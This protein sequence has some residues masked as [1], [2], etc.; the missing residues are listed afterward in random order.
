MSPMPSQDERHQFE[1]A[2]AAVVDAAR[3]A[4]AARV[5]L[6]EARE[7]LRR[8]ERAGR[9][10]AIHEG[11]VK[12][13]TATAQDQIG[14]FTNSREAFEAFTDPRVGA[15]MLDDATPFLLFPLRI[16]TRFGTAMEHGV[17]KA[18]LWVRVYPDDCLIDSFEPLP[19]ETEI[20][21]A[22]RYWANMWK[23]HGIEAQE[24][25]AWRSFVASHGSGRAAWLEVN[26]KP[27]NI[28]AKPNN[29]ATDRLV[30]VIPTETPIVNPEADEVSTFWKA[31]WLADGK[32]ADTDQ[33]TTTLRTNIGNDT[34][35]QALIDG[36]KP[37]NLSDEPPR[38]LARNQ[39]IV[40]VAFV[41]FPKTADQ[42]A[43]L[44][45][46]SQPARSHL[47]P[48]RFVLLAYADG[49]AKVI[50]ELGNPIPW[51]LTVGPDP[52]APDTE[53]I[54]Q[55]N[56]EIKVG[57][58]LKWL[59]DFERA[60]Q[61]GMGFRV[62]L[63]SAMATQGFERLL[64]IGLRLSA[65]AMEGKRLLENLL[66]H[67]RDGSSG[68]AVLKQGTP[69]NNTEDESSGFTRTDEA[70]RTFDERLHP[71]AA[72]RASAPWNKKLDGEWL[73]DALGIDP[74]LLN[75]V[76][77]SRNTDQLEAQAMN[78]ALWPATL[79]YSLETMM[80]PAFDGDDM[81]GVRWFYERFVTGRGLLPAIRL[82]HQPYGILPT[83]VMS[84]LQWPD[85]RDLRDIRGAG[86]PSGFRGVLSG[87]EKVLKVMGGDWAEMAKNVSR[88][89]STGDPHQI[90]LDIIGLHP[91]SVE[92]Y[93]RYAESLDDLYNRMRFYGWGAEFMAQ[94]TA[95]EYEV[96]GMAHL[97]HL[98]Y[99]GDNMPDIL[100]RFFIQSANLLQGPFVDDLPLSETAELQNVTTD[101]WNYIEW[102]RSAAGTSLDKLR[103]ETGFTGNKVPKALLYLLLRHALL[104]AYWDSSLRLSQLREFMDADAI[105]AARRESPFIH[106]QQEPRSGESRWRMLYGRNA[107]L[108]G[109]PAV[110]VADYI[111][112]VIGTSPAASRLERMLAA[113]DV[114]KNLPTARLER[115][116]A[117]HLDTC[118]Y[119]LDAW[120]QGLVHY[121]LSLTR[122]K[123]EAG[124]T[125][126]EKGIFLGTFGW[127]EEVRPR[128]RK[129]DPVPP[130][131]GLHAS[132]HAAGLQPLVHDST[133]GG[134][135]HAP[136][137]N[138]AVAA[139]VLRNG[140]LA[141][142]TPANPGAFAVNLSSQR[143]RLALSFLEGIR[144]GQSLGAL[145]GYQ[146]ERGLHDA[147]VL[148]EVDEHIHALR[149]KFPLVADRH[150]DTASPPTASIETIEARNVVDGL[151]L[152]EHVKNNPS[153]S[154]PFGFNDL[155]P[156]D[157]AQRDAINAEVARLIDTTD[158][159]ADLKVA[160]SVY[161]AVQSNY[162]GVAATLESSGNG[163]L[164]PEPAVIETPRSGRT[165]THRVAL[166]LRPGL[167]MDVTPAVIGIMPLPA[168]WMTPRGCA[169]PALN[170]W[171]AKML[172]SPDTVACMVSW[173]DPAA[174]A[175]KTE[176]V[177]QENIGL[178][179]IDLLYTASLETE[180]AM[181]EL[182]DRIVLYAHRKFVPRADCPVMIL[183]RMP[184][185]GMVTF[186]ELASLI[187]SLRPLVL[188][189]RPLRPTDAVAQGRASSSM[190]ALVKVEPER[191]TKVQAALTTLHGN[192]VTFRDTLEPLHMIP[193]G[194]TQAAQAAREAQIRAG[195][196]NRLTSFVDLL[197]RASSFGLGDAGWGFILDFK[198]TWFESLLDVVRKLKDRFTSRLAEC[199]LRLAAYDLA[200]AGMTEPERF[201]ALAAA[202][203][204]VRAAITIPPPANAAAYRLAVGV[205]RNVFSARLTQLRN[206]LTM[207][208]QSVVTLHTA[209]RAVVN[210]PPLLAELDLELVDLTD[211]DQAL[212]KMSADLLARSKRLIKIIEDA[213]L[214]PAADLIANYT[215]AADPAARA[216]LLVEAAKKL[217]GDDA[218]LIPEFKLD[219]DQGGTLQAAYNAGV[220]GDP[221]IWQ[222]TVKMTPEP[223]DT[224]LYGI[225]RVREK[226]Q[227][228]EQSVMLEGAFGAAE[229]ELVPIQI[230]WKAGE[231]W[232]G[233]EYPLT[234]VPD[235]DRLCY[236]AHFVQPF[237]H[238]Q[239]QSGLLIDD[240]TEVIPAKQETTGLTFHF[241]RP[242]AEAP[243]ALLL[244]T[245]PAFIGSW[246]WQDIV[247][248]VRETLD[249]SKSRAV[250]PVHIDDT[251]Y[252]RFLP[253]T[254]MA[255]TLYQVSIM[256][257]L[258]RNNDYFAYLE[259]T[260]G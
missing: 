20:A 99:T 189:S 92:H 15:P 137:L 152:V 39:V 193:P 213:R 244:V 115:L 28:G 62:D 147:W 251:A 9:S 98:G 4:E 230:P 31:V 234:Y 185:A 253:M 83:T 226:M 252:A 195:L 60:V 44:R 23:A 257:N 190:D 197:V 94:L 25:G 127:L 134:Y 6:F 5:S 104:Q 65:D 79:G 13:R 95:I 84:R 254:V 173:F 233:L 68:F 187:R 40:T 171:L 69:T 80:H 114:L 88:V 17:P 36:Y 160:D 27:L 118:T 208:T 246:Q 126:T 1:A 117:E 219:D 29:L 64:V 120:Q 172:P 240:W 75:T 133:N 214:T 183:Y 247:D 222:R 107:Q 140:Y 164:P 32:R 12:D 203:R 180:Q 116:F 113:L 210:G 41:E 155:P 215:A 87:I 178:Q 231:H 19:S 141:N 248:A 111:T 52:Q 63:T 243:Q 154:Y 186:F 10:R 148:G 77:G 132:F 43:T 22:Q 143:V 161:H 249:R 129:L 103:E 71:G 239:W 102:L 165:V 242:N 50:E 223:A 211:F 198:R 174:N 105:K 72:L 124:A 217:L 191:I 163:Q 85:Q 241:D 177:T 209:V 179:P 149:K 97:A 89:G 3:K 96:T 232:L 157:Q 106:I 150:S 46:W 182:D 181:S 168:N 81:D 66:S 128:M 34:R 119:R 131:P 100:N 175:L 238:T 146:L 170:S 206:L 110:R 59:T 125:V 38:G 176:T 216:Q 108:T 33:A 37:I 169:E 78:V 218:I 18:Q 123:T 121:A 35:A 228:W 151:R 229:P 260:D 202:E 255:A 109:D 256:T 135:I 237:D 8:A 45:S 138:Q 86:N 48:D 42:A 91:A 207:A 14:S 2:Q 73:A 225:A 245:P 192:L 224:W 144:Q 167:A 258:A 26:Y 227:A 158:A 221:L 250:E 24:R 76:G 93:Q 53:Q 30:L 74:A 145:L 54:R 259:A 11:R 136:S 90:L 130:T 236:T 122:Y 49:G 162:D 47:L 58:D 196:D 159:I 70:D 55:E 220:N 101:P 21:S 204:Y 7:G 16:E 200:Q 112:G 188:H 184:I 51:P 57:E 201:S 61:I 153:P 205:S 142:A 156:A 166:H 199:D 67:H 82:G 56:G 194:E 235:G 139:A 212:I